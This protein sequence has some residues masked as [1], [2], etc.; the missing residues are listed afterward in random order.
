[1]L[2]QAADA[3]QIDITN[4][5]AKA[6]AIFGSRTMIKFFAAIGGASLVWVMLLSTPAAAAHILIANC[7][8]KSVKICAHNN[9]K[10][11]EAVPIVSY[12]INPGGFAEYRCQ[13]NCAFSISRKNDSGCTNGLW[14]DHSWG[15][16]NYQLIGLEKTNVGTPDEAY[17]SSNLINGS[18]YKCPEPPGDG[19]SSAD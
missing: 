4:G 18:I 15:S 3:A 13:A 17:K 5:Q 16:G 11:W 2:F 7:L 14:L 9:K 1:V 10:L 8:D 12:S 6:P 19:T